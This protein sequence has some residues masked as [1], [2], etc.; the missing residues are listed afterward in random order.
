MMQSFAT[1]MI[2]AR[3]GVGLSPDSTIVSYTDHWAVAEH[4]LTGPWAVTGIIAGAL[5]LV[6]VLLCR[7]VRRAACGEAS[8]RPRIA[9]DQRGTAT[10]E[11]AMVFPIIMF[12]TLLLV[13]TT[14]AMVGNMFVHYAAMSGARAA[15]VHIPTWQVGSDL[16]YEN[17]NEINTS[18]TGQASKMQ[19]IREAVWFALV[20]VCGQLEQGN[21]DAEPY[22]GGLRIL[23]EQLADDVPG[24][25]DAVAAERLRYAAVNTEVTIESVQVV[26]GIVEFESQTG[27]AVFGPKDPICVRVD[28][29]LNLAVPYVRFIF[30]DGQHTT[31]RGES[32]YTNVTAR[33]TL[34]NE[35]ID[36]SMPPLPQLPRN[37]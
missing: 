19:S 7:R 28:H 8:C 24:W 35:G 21:I 37:Q 15:I 25:I 20:P 33:H 14:M 10:I 2:Q 30:S 11:F 26:Q 13:Q 36:P 5:L 6:V 31:A 32:A 18:L 23:H 4:V 27:Q 1:A 16:V 3:M 12:L 22:V 34:H 9:R 29:R 17:I